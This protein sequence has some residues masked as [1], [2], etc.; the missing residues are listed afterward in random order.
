L[1]ARTVDVLN[2]TAMP[3][4]I[5]VKPSLLQFL[6]VIKCLHERFGFPMPIKKFVSLSAASL[7]SEG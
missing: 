5:L 4:N 1:P 6:L 3:V 2:I 7:H